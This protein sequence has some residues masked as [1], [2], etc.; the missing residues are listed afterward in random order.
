MTDPG[1]KNCRAEA[2]GRPR[3]REL[4]FLAP[5]HSKYLDVEFKLVRKGRKQRSGANTRERM[6]TRGRN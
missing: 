4:R 3:G 5:E 2:A 6:G 1:S